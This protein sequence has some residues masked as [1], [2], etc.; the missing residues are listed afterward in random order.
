MAR[1]GSESYFVIGEGLLTESAGGRDRTLAP[2]VEA[3]A[4]PFRFSRMGPRGAALGEANRKKL[5]RAMTA[6]GGGAG[7]I[8]AGYTYLGQFVDHDLTFDKTAVT[9]GE[10][11]SPRS[12]EASNCLPVFHETPT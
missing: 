2:S 10:N 1:H 9:L 7:P 5:A 6:G 11:V 12:Q 8:P 4:A 3:Q